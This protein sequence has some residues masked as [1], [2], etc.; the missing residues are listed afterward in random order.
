MCSC[1]P[2]GLHDLWI[3]PRSSL[4]QVL[5]LILESGNKTH[6]VRTTDKCKNT[7]ELLSQSIHTTRHRNTSHH[8]HRLWHIKRSIHKTKTISSQT[9]CQS[10]VLTLLSGTAETRYTNT[11]T[12]HKATSKGKIVGGGRRLYFHRLSHRPPFRRTRFRSTTAHAPP[13][14]SRTFPTP[15]ISSLHRNFYY[16]HSN[17]S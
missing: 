14:D 4:Q 1:I 12:Y 10:V 3:C 5:Q 17:I 11:L 13:Q 8:C 6:I 7:P 2:S 9:R 15:A 16:I